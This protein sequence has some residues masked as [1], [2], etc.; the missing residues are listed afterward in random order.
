[1]EYYSKRQHLSFGPSMT[2]TVKKLLIISGAVFLLQTIVGQQM[3]LIFGLVPAMVWHEYF[4]WQL[5]TYIFLHGGFF[6][7]LFN[8]FALW[9]FGCEFER[10][11]GSRVFLRYF[12]I[13]GIGAAIC[14][15][16]ITPNLFIPTIGMS[17][18]I[19]G[20]LL[21]YGWFFPNRIIYIYLFFPIK[22]KYF[23]MIFGAIELYASIAGT[24]GGIAH[25]THLGGM[26]FG[27]IYLNYHRIWGFLYQYYMRW[28]WSRL[29]RRYKVINGGKDSD[30]TFH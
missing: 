2:P 15:V 7:L 5:G 24:G 23:V 6:H 11:W 14:T 20:I 8:L 9:M 28:K 22:A 10:Y 17:G 30:K 16:L 1:M 13:T 25:I 3:N 12:F 27:I 21:A 26:V 29:K 18:V 4:L 19:Y